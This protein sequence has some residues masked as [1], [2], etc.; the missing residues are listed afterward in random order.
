VRRERKYNIKGEDLGLWM[1]SCSTVWTSYYTKAWE[2]WPF[3]E[4]DA[5]CFCG[6]VA[7]FFVFIRFESSDENAIRG[8]TNTLMLEFWALKFIVK[9]ICTQ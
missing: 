2:Y 9:N 5:V 7:I 6:F 3:V 1:N 8:H 4:V